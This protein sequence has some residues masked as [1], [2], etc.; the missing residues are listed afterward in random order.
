MTQVKTQKTFHSRMPKK[1]DERRKL[2]NRAIHLASSRQSEDDNEQ[3]LF[4]KIG[5]DN[6]E[7]YGI[8]YHYLDEIL[9]PKFITPVPQSKKIIS[10]VIPYRGDFIAVLDFSSMLE[11]EQ[12]AQSIASKIENSWFVIVSIE[13]I[14]VALL[15]NEVVGNCHYRPESLGPSMSTKLEVQNDH[16]LGVFDGKTAIVNLHRLFTTH[17]VLSGKNE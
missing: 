13:K 14:K 9:R 1:P 8:P 17:H 2:R 6:N 3:E 16:V 4:L 5:L 15:V 7:Y 11:I 10:G 12:P